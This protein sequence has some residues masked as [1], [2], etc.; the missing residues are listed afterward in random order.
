V[1][2][3][4]YIIGRQQAVQSLMA[5]E[6]QSERALRCAFFAAH[7]EGDVP[8]DYREDLISLPWWRRTS[9]A[10]VPATLPLRRDACPGT[11]RWS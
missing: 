11:A 5:E 4:T 6:H 1:G 9:T 7:N 8:D 10:R 3:V 2:K